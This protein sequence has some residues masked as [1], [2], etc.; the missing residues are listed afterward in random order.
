MAANVRTSLVVLNDL[1]SNEVTYGPVQQHS[2]MNWLCEIRIKGQPFSGSGSTAQEAKC[3]AAEKALN[4]YYQTLIGAPVSSGT[5][6]ASVLAKFMSVAKPNDLLRVI[7]S[8]KVV[9]GIVRIDDYKP[10]E[11]QVICISSGNKCIA[12]DRLSVGGDAIYDC[13]AEVLARRCF[14]RYL[15]QQLVKFARGTPSIYESEPNGRSYVRVQQRY[16]F[17]MY[18]NKEPCGDADLGQSIAHPNSAHGGKLRAKL[19]AGEG[20]HPT[21]FVNATQGGRLRTMSCSDKIL[22]WNV[23]GL[24]GAML[25]H[26]IRPVYLESLHLGILNLNVFHIQRALVGRLDGFQAAPPFCTKSLSIQ[27]AIPSNVLSGG[28]PSVDISMNWCTGDTDDV[29]IVN[30]NT[31]KIHETLWPTSS[32]SSQTV[33]RLSKKELCRSFLNLLSLRVPAS[34]L[35][36][37]AATAATY[38]DIKRQS[39]QYQTTSRSLTDFFAARGMGVWIKKDKVVDRFPLNGL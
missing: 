9:A 16:K 38:D 7:M 4:F 33:S 32:R 23:L 18:I 11:H 10:R 39:V 8:H 35:T 30:A 24:Q 14:Q 31:G 13:H 34:G 5:V 26:Y 12:L 37:R 17:H 29:E 15:L 22:R 2:F 25:T 36:H 27:E 6:A 21:E 1:F 28:S 19:D 20:V 3:S